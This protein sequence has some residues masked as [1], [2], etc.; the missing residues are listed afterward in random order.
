M[1]RL[2]ISLIILAGLLAAAD[3]GIRLYS[4]S[5]VGNELKQSLGLSERPSVSL[6][7]WPFTPD[8]FSGHLPSASFSA[9]SFSARGVQLRS[10]SVS[11]ED[12]HFPSG[13]LVFGGGGTIHAARGHGTASLTGEDITGALHHQGLPLDVSIH[14][15]RAEVGGAGIT[16]GLSV[17]LEGDTVVL[18]PAAT[19]IASARILLPRIVRGL[20]YTSLELKGNAAVL[21][22]RLRNAVFVVPG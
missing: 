12:I 21:S 2:L 11:L 19:T 1:R 10:V 18:T 22:F 6:G 8:L 17:K 4:Q 9:R 3:Y 14:G 16:V 7:G 15:G 20:A 5:V 13:R